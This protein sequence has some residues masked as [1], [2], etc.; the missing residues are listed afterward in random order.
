MAAVV[1]VEKTAI[2]AVLARTEILGKRC[3]F[4]LR[5]FFALPKDA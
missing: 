2:E 4:G 5:G 3:R 1:F